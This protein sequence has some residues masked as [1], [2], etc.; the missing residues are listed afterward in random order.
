VVPLHHGKP[1]WD[2]SGANGLL[3]QQIGALGESVGLE[4]AGRW[5]KFRE[6]AHFQFTGGL[7]LAEL[8]TGK[9]V[10]VKAYM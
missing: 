4:W 5:K 1:V 6:L 7:T 8:Q 10:Q 2:T 9:S 3:W